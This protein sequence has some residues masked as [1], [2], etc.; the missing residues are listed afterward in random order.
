MIASVPLFV[1]YD[2]VLMREEHRA[3]T[4]FSA[5]EIQQLLD[6]LAGLVEP[7][8]TFYPAFTGWRTDLRRR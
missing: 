6:G 3:A 7:V 1:E 4:G 2:E 8:E 5:I